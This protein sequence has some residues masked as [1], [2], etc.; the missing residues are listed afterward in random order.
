MFVILG[1]LG[2]KIRKVPAMEDIEII[3][4]SVSSP[5]LRRGKK[6]LGILTLKEIQHLEDVVPNPRGTMYVICNS[7][8]D[9]C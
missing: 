2:L 6:V 7:K 4:A 5:N 3:F 9:L 1:G 8:E